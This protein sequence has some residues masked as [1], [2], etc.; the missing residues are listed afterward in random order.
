[1]SSVRIGRKYQ[2]QDGG[3]RGV[4]AGGDCLRVK[5]P[6]LNRKDEC[7]SSLA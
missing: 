3:L 5:R 7:R 1:M 2:R 4:F 6:A